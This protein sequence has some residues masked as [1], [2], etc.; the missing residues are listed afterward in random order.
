MMKKN[1]ERLYGFTMGSRS[2]H[3]TDLGGLEGGVGHLHHWSCDYQTVSCLHNVGL[4]H[5]SSHQDEMIGRSFK[6]FLSVA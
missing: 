2:D 6:R 5:I 4:E 3:L 1:N